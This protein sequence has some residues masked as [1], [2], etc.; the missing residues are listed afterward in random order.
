LIMHVFEFTLLF[1]VQLIVIPI[2]VHAVAA[3]KNKDFR[4]TGAPILG[5]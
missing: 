3:N 4:Y 2:I 5:I 1:L